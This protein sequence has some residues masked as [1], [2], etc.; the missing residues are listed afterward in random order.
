[1]SDIRFCHEVKVALNKNSPLR[2]RRWAIWRCSYSIACLVGHIA[3][4][5]VY[6]L[7][8]EKVGFSNIKNLTQELM[9]TEEQILKAIGILVHVRF[10]LLE[11]LFRYQMKRKK[12]KHISKRF[13]VLIALNMELL[14]K[15]VN[16][17]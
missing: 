3:A 2:D 8:S 5:D 11:R 17:S 4:K 15:F 10:R 7:I 14:I 9:P 12:L 1:M 16:K 6:K 13:P